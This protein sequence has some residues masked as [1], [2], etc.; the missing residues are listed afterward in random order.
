MSTATTDFTPPP[1]PPPDPDPFRYGWRI[2]VDKI[3]ERTLKVPLT[4]EDV[5]HPQEGDFIV[6]S[7]IHHLIVAYLRGGLR[8]EFDGR[9]GWVVLG[10]TRVDW[11]S[12][13]GWVHGPDLALFSGFKGGW[14]EHDGTFFVK[15]TKSKSELVMEVTSSTTRGNDYGLKL[16][17]YFLVGV[18]RYIIIDVPDSKDRGAIQLFGYKAGKTQF[19]PWAPDDKGRLFL[20]VADLWLSCAGMEVFLEDRAGRRLPGYVESVRRYTAA[21]QRIHELEA[22]IAKLK[23]KK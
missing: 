17:E 6:N 14:T 11:Q 3:N 12:R 9:K 18:P 8:L 23:K 4:L 15:R 1:A 22:E 10:D 21:E 20:G 5:L 16:R 7:D 2:V 19:E 13:Y